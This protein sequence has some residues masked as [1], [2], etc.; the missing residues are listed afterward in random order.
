MSDAEQTRDMRTTVRDVREKA[1][2][3]PITML[4]AYD[5]VTAAIVDEQGV[6]VILVGDS[7]GNTK[8]GHESP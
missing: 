2:D 5:A 1:G 3:E 6:D 8:L 7:I 4:T